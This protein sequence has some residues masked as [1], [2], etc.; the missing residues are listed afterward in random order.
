MKRFSITMFGIILSATAQATTLEEIDPVAECELY[1]SLY[2]MV[3]EMT[4]VSVSNDNPTHRALMTAVLTLSTSLQQDDLDTPVENILAK[5]KSTVAD[6]VAGESVI[7]CHE[8]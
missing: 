5:V 6:S 1:M 8:Y 7:Q 4:G 2:D 3:G